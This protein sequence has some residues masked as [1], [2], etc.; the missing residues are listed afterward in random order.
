MKILEPRTYLDVETPLGRGNIWLIKD[1]G[2]EMDTFYTVII[3]EGAHAGQIFDF[4]N[5]DIRVSANYSLH[6]GRWQDL[7]KKIGRS[8]SRLESA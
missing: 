3:R 4:P 5:S 2:L 7:S 1:Y 8:S 6:R